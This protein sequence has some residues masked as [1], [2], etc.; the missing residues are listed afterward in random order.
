MASK[1][2][3][4]ASENTHQ[5]HK[6]RD[7]ARLAGVSIATVSAVIN[8]TARVSPA[9]TQ[10]V[11]KAMEALDYHPDQV[12]RSLKVGKTHVI[13]M[14]IPDVTNEFFPAVM[15]G[16]EDVARQHDY[17]VML[18]NSNEDPEQEQ[19]HLNTLFSRRVDGVL[20][21]C[22]DPSSAY[23]RLVRRRFPIVFVDRIPQGAKCCAVSTDNAGAAHMAV[24]HLIDLGHERIAIVGGP[25][26]LSPFVGRLEGFRRAM[27]EAH[28]AIRDEYVKET[29]SRVEAG[30]IAALE[31]LRL[32][33][34][35]TAVFASNNKLL[36]GLV[37][38]IF[39][40]G[41][42]IPRQLSVVGFDDFPGAEYF[43]PALT[44]VAQ[45]MHELGRTAM[46]LLLGMMEDDTARDRADSEIVLL[47]GEL[48]IRQSTA[49][50]GG[51][52]TRAA[53]QR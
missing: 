10:R 39:E 28:L 52:S 18:C 44:A 33:E 30:H 15:D 1:R 16:V 8:G 47:K 27:Q 22:A 35:P 41:L 31:L 7:V 36:L 19:R 12:A 26:V 49:P 48:R 34:P 53:A 45:P 20:L 38:A 25:T 11:Q 2:L 23:D 21:A 46:Q 32:P 51:V 24:R 13:G 4:T 5:M 50:P 29:T 42:T 37:R 43:N 3:G 9:L 14:I 6:M 40:L 17:S